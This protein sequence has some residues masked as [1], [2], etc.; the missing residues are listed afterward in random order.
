VCSSCPVRCSRLVKPGGAQ[1]GVR[2]EVLPIGQLGYQDCRMPFV[3]LRRRSEM[4]G[5]AVIPALIPDRAMHCQGASSG[6]GQSLLQL[7]RGFS[8]DW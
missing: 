1:A 5:E 6:G 4:V 3:S 8:V 2:L 7:G